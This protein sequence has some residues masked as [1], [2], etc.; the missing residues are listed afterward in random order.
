MSR[1]LTISEAAN[2]L[3]VST[4]TLRRWEREGRIAPPQRTEGGQRRYDL[5]QLGPRKEKAA[6]DQ[7]RTIA[8]ARVSSHDQ[9]EDL[10]R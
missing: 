7:R 8:Y 5:S 6:P 1:F 10:E 2:W 3:G 4:Q 9:K